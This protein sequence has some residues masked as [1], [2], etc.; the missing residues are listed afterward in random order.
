MKKIDLLLHPV[1]TRIVQQLLVNQPLTTY[2]LMERLGDVPQATLYRQMKL[3]S[4]A[5]IIRIVDTKNVRGKAEHLYAVN[6]DQLQINQDEFLTASAEEHLQY[7]TVFQA[8]LLQQVTDYLMT[9]SPE[10][11]QK[12][13]FGYWHAPLHLTDQEFEQF[14]HAINE[15]LEQATKKEKR[16][17]RKTRT[18]A[19]M[20]IPNNSGESSSEHV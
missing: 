12:D 5:A 10:H 15:I 6:Q 4:D 1:R 14:T 19:S 13:G 18:F 2:Q 17:D 3:L 8:T 16:P 20:F 9:T 11:Y 7:F